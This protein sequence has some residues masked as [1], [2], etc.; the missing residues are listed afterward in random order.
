MVA[1]YISMRPILDLCEQSTWRPGESVSQWWWEQDGINLEVAKK[2]AA[3]S[4]TVSKSKLDSELNAEPVGEE[5][6]RG[7]SGSSGAECSG[8]EE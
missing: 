1:Q 2:R 7:T 5:D 3:E 8:A 6:S 4:A